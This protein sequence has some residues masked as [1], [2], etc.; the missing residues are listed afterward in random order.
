[1]PTKTNPNH[2][3]HEDHEQTP[4]LHVPH[5]FFNKQIEEEEEEVFYIRG[6]YINSNWK[7]PLASKEVE[8]K[9]EKI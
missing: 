2:E 9:L 1:M 6:I 3:H 7:P 5:L 4:L 8:S